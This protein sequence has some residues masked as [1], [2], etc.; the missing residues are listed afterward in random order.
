WADA[1]TKMESVAM[2]FSVCKV[3]C[4][5]A[6]GDGITGM[7]GRYHAM[8]RFTKVFRRVIDLIEP[9]AIPLPASCGAEYVRDGT[10]ATVSGSAALIQGGWRC[11]FPGSPS[12][13]IHRETCPFGGGFRGSVRE[14]AAL[15]VHLLE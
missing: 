11:T 2:S 15:P 10:L 9:P 7:R 4:C 12:A 14:L 8:G 3:G 1:G 5:G 13:R 6:A